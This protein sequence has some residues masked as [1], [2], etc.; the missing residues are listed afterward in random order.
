VLAGHGCRISPRTGLRGPPPTAESFGEER[1][2]GW[3]RAHPSHPR[4]DPAVTG[5]PGQAPARPAAAVDGKERKLA[6]A[7]G[8]KNVHLLAAVTHVPGLVIAQDK[9]AKGGKANGV[10]HF[11]PLLEP[12]PLDDVIQATR[13]NAVFLRRGRARTTCGPSLGT[14]RT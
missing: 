8:S 11:R 1:G 5:D 10:T 14:S 9:V 12:L 2:D 4:L 3:F 6:T 13:D 7:G